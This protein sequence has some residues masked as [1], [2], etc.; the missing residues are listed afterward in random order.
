VANGFVDFIWRY[1]DL[2]AAIRKTLAEDANARYTDSDLWAEY[3]NPSGQVRGWS[4]DKVSIFSI[5]AGQSQP[6]YWLRDIDMGPV[7][8]QLM[9][10]NPAAQVWFPPTT[11]A[12]DP[13]AA[14]ADI[15]CSQLLDRPLRFFRLNP[16]VMNLPTL[17]AVYASRFPWLLSQLIRQ[18]RVAVESPES[19]RAVD[20]ALSFLKKQWKTPQSDQQYIA[21][22]KLGAE[23]RAAKRKQSLL[24]R[25]FAAASKANLEMA[26][27][28]FNQLADTLG[29]SETD[30][31]FKQ[32]EIFE[33]RD[34]EE[35]LLKALQ[36]FNEAG[37]MADDTE[38]QGDLSFLLRASVVREAG[39]AARILIDAARR[40][41]FP[42]DFEPVCDILTRNFSI[43]WK[44]KRVLREQLLTG[45]EA[46]VLAN[47]NI[48]LVVLRC[49]QGDVPGARRAING[50]EELRR[51]LGKHFEDALGT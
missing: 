8:F 20:E 11:Y 46:K 39:E 2:E 48:E 49:L 24:K 30:R 19:K 21:E 44:L 6:S 45:L 4:L 22:L 25:L 5:G 34:A 33:R 12:L 27:R 29:V 1:T 14:E 40:I 37:W 26:T 28:V 51:W 31:L 3:V 16:P 17:A 32:R 18:I 50:D 38:D 15:V 43:D 13:A 10:T 23:R 35:V 42:V 41:G 9:P 7:M 36:L 47:P